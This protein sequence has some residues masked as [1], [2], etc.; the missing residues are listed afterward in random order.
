MAGYGYHR[1]YKYLILKKMKKAFDPG[2]PVLE[3]AASG[4]EATT[5]ILEG[6]DL[7]MRLLD[8]ERID[9]IVNGTNS[10]CSQSAPFLI[11]ASTRVTRQVS[12]AKDTFPF[13]SI[14]SFA[15]CH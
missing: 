5:T 2:D 15:L 3:L 7:W 11:R 8:Q 13:N 12:R 10:M 6:D 9:A 14:L 1:Y 4:S